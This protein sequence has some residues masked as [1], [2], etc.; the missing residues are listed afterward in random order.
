[1]GVKSLAAKLVMSG[2][3]TPENQLL[4]GLLCNHFF[5]HFLCKICI[6]NKMHNLQA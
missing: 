3:S 1:M 4:M 5:L 6:R 2:E